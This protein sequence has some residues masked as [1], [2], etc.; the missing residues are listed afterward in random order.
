MSARAKCRWRTAYRKVIRACQASGLRAQRA[1]ALQGCRAVLSLT[2]LLHANRCPR[3]KSGAGLENALSSRDRHPYLEPAMAGR[4]IKLLVITLEGR[5]VRHPEAGVRQPVIPDGINGA[6]DR[7][8]VVL[9][10]EHRV[11]LRG[12]AHAAELA[13]QGGEVGDLDAGDIVQIAGVIA[14]AA[15]AIGDGPDPVRNV[16]VLLM[17]AAPQQRNAGAAF[18][19]EAATD[20]GDQESLAV[21]K[22]RRGEIVEGGGIHEDRLLK[23]KMVEKRWGADHLRRH[24]EM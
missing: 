14:I 23:L 22:A 9:M 19:A 3:V 20:A 18:V 21:L 4:G 17:K 13:R 10:G 15:D 5:R 6:P 8:D 16:P 24:A 1:A 12:D 11:S 7:G 2:R